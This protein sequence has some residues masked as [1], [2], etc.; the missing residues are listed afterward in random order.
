MN[1][2]IQ[3]V[4]QKAGISPDQAKTAVETV[5]GFVKGKLPEPIAGQ[6]ESFLQSQGGTPSMGDAIKSLRGAMG[7]S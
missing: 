6:V 2:L 3:L 5:V 1:D 7:G 4:A